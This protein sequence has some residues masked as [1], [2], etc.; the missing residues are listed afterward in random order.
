MYNVSDSS[1]QPVHFELYIQ[2]SIEKGNV[3]VAQET[4]GN[5]GKNLRTASFFEIFFDR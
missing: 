2:T 5:G 4:I 3:G 1:R